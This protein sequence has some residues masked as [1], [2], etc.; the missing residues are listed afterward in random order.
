M[1]TPTFL[2]AY[3]HDNGDG[4]EYRVDGPHLNP[5]LGERHLHV[6]RK[7]KRKGEY[8]WNDGGS[9]HDKGR[10][11]ANESGIKKARAI[12]AE[13]LKVDANSLQLIISIDNI[14]RLWITYE[15]ADHVA[16]GHLGG[17][18]EG[19]AI[20]ADES[21]LIVVGIERTQEG[22]NARP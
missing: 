20:F 9:R 2:L 8:S 1:D 22:E 21:W 11:P 10:F 18:T 15:D 17:T 5:P 4:W 6:R 13:R 19:I 7:S 16:C 3:W 12:A 14:D